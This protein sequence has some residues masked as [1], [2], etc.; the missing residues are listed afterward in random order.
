MLATKEQERKALE[1][2]REIVAELGE[3]SYVGT[4]FDGCFEIAESN[5]ENDF[6]CSLKQRHEQAAADVEV[7]KGLASEYKKEAEHLNELLEKEQEWKPYEDHGNVTQDDYSKLAEQRDTR[8]LTDDEAKDILYDWFG[9][10]K[11]MV[12]IHRTVPKYEVNRHRLLRNVGS[13]DRRPAYNATD[14]NYIRFDCG[15]MTYELHNGDLR[16]FVH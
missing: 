1:R 13:I 4:A 11:E 6:L 10:A 14:W 7:L 16:F 9:F 3:D 2:I 8:F 15:M 5:I 12:V